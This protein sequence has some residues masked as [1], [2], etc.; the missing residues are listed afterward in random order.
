MRVYTPMTCRYENITKNITSRIARVMGITR[1]KAPMPMIGTMIRSISSVPYAEEEIM[2]GARTPM[3]TGLARRSCV[4]CSETLGGP[5]MRF[6][7]R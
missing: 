4:S 7:R 5:R 2:S 6:L 1:L 3:A